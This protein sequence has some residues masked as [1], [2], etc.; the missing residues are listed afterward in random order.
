MNKLLF[1]LSILTIQV[2]LLKAVDVKIY[3]KNISKKDIYANNELLF[4]L[5]K[6]ERINFLKNFLKN[7]ANLKTINSQG[8]TPLM[9]A[10]I[11]EYTDIV[12]VLLKYKADPNQTVSILNEAT[13]LYV[14]SQNGNIKIVKLLLSH[15]ANPNIA[16]KSTTD[17]NGST[18]L[19]MAA[20]N[21]HHE[22]VK[23]LLT[24]GA[25]P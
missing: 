3:D 18:P 9:K 13:P 11:D 25:D 8:L 7:N 21:G 17:N 4:G 24:H 22:I 2:S 5:L 1:F 14:A 20:Q 15:K 19:F 6:P 16:I 23:L 12:H 10:I